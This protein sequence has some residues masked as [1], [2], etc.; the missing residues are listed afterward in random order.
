[1]K[2]VI[3][4][5]SNGFIGKWLVKKMVAEGLEVIAVVRNEHSDIRDLP[6]SSQ[7]KIVY[8]E[9]AHIDRL[10]EDVDATASDTFY[11]LAWTGSCG[12]L[13][14]DYKVQLTNVIESCKALEV[15]N[16]LGCKRF[17]QAGTITEQLVKETQVAL[18]CNFI[19]GL[20]KEML[21]RLIA[22]KCETMP[23]EYVWMQFSNVYGPLNRSGNMIYYALSEMNEGRVP[24]FSK[25][26]TWYDFIYIK[27]LVKALYLLGESPVSSNKSYFIGSGEPRKLK[28]YLASIDEAFTE[29]HL[30]IG[31]REEEGITY[32]K[33][34]FDTSLLQKEIGFHA[35]YP[36]ERGIKETISWM[37]GEK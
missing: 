21:H 28:A 9:M 17:M 15:A 20:C 3:I 8:Q 1:M 33:A 14:Q 19:Y 30:N 22:M 5:G 37:K 31:G 34:W 23:I 36:F 29:G 26:E 12:A 16:K 13:R 25:G 24:T 35:D 6:K 4:T 7:I 32:S 18:S 10:L 2:R 11:H 27:D